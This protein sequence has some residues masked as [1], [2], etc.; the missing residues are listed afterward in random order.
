MLP[1]M[2]VRNTSAMG[3]AASAM[4]RA[5]EATGGHALRM[6]SSTKSRARAPDTCQHANWQITYY[7]EICQTILSLLSRSAQCSIQTLED[8]NEHD[9]V[10]SYTALRSIGSMKFA[11]QDRRCLPTQLAVP[12]PMHWM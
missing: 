12:V 7:S 1:G 11:V 9:T 2:L 5:V 10:I 8:G 4:V 6:K 3:I